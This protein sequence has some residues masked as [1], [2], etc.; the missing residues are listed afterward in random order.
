MSQKQRQNK[1]VFIT[2]WNEES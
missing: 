2:D 1:T